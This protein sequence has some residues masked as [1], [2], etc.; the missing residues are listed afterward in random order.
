EVDVDITFEGASPSSQG[1]SVPPDIDLLL[2]GW[3]VGK[4]FSEV[5]HQLPEDIDM[6]YDERWDICTITFEGYMLHFS[7]GGIL[8]YIMVTKDGLGLSNG[9][10]VGS[11]EAQ[12]ITLLGTPSGILTQPG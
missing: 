6:V 3:K 2:S 11:P 7:G 5:N 12:V 9:L 4:A 8:E 10:I 1:N